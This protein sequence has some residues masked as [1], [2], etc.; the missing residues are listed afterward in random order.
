MFPNTPV[1]TY[2]MLFNTVTYSGAALHRQ[3]IDSYI[4]WNRS[5]CSS[6]HSAS[7]FN[8]SF[9]VNDLSQVVNAGCSNVTS[10]RVI[11]RYRLVYIKQSI[12]SVFF[13]DLS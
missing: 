6:F 8:F 12:R 5:I 11:P 4:R 9:D 2:Q 10:T 3:A 13:L 1:S 7:I